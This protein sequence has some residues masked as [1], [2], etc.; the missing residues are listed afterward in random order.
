ML[1]LKGKDCLRELKTPKL[2]DI[3]KR[4]ILIYK[5]TE[6]LKIRGEIKCI[7]EVVY[8][9]IIFNGNKKEIT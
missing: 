3:N 9:K 7:H 5:D 6:N 8:L 2:Y 4:H 1:W